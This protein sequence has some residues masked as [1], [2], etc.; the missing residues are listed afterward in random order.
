MHNCEEFRE[1]ITEHIIDREDLTADPRFQPELLI[2][3]ECAEFYSDSCEMMA[4]LSS[5]DASISENQWRNIE[6][7]LAAGLTPAFA[8]RHK[9]SFNLFDRRSKVRAYTE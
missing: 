5:V 8:H 1:R 4:A 7:R 9:S 6:L 2:C 3:S